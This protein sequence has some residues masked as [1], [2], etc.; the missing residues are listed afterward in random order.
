MDDKS[1]VGR[2]FGNQRATV[3]RIIVN[4]SN[5]SKW[6]IQTAQIAQAGSVPPFH[7]EGWNMVTTSSDPLRNSGNRRFR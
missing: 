7:D 6:Q 5:I 2:A 1:P 4:E 3:A